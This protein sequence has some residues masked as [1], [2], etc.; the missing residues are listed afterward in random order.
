MWLRTR[1]WQRAVNG[2]KIAAALVLLEQGLEALLLS[3]SLAEHPLIVIAA[4]GALGF[5][6]KDEPSEQRG[7]S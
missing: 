2:V 7:A 4:L 5:P 3:V 1:R 6:V